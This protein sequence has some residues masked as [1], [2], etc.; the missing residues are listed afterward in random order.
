ME[1]YGVGKAY[2][3]RSGSGDCDL[4]D[5]TRVKKKAKFPLADYPGVRE[6]SISN[7]GEGGNTS[8]PALKTQE[9]APVAS[10]RLKTI[11]SQNMAGKRSV[12]RRASIES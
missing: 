9:E 7:G 12:G 11:E 6:G 4:K 10:A 1:R 5:E 8:P 3:D 2:R